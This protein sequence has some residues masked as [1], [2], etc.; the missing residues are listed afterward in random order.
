MK[1]SDELKI[2]QKPTTRVTGRGWLIAVLALAAFT[3]KSYADG[4]RTSGGGGGGGHTLF[5]TSAVENADGT[6]TLPLYK[7]TSHGQT[8]YY[9]LT[10]A[11]DGNFAQ[12]YGIN[13]AQKLANAANTGA[14]QKVTIVNG[15]I[16]F[17]ATVDFNHIRQVTPGP[18]GFPPAAAQPGA[19]G[20]TGYSPVIQLPNGIIVN[21]PHVATARATRP[22][23]SALTSSTIWLPTARP[24]RFKAETRSST[25][26]LNHPVP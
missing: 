11:S 9:V 13:K 12:Q 23:Q 22:R 6:A 16:D 19:V 2:N 3:S 1:H 26:R 10:D 18:T 25:S 5:I 15:V 14:V 7:G 4:G 24:T 20:G 17:P 21:A 8:V